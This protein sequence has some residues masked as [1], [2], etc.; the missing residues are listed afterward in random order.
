MKP[1]KQRKQLLIKK[2]LFL[3]LRMDRLFTTH[4]DVDLRTSSNC[5]E[6]ETE[7][8]IGPKSMGTGYACLVLNREIRA[9][10]NVV[11]ELWQNAN[12]RCCVDGGTNRW[13]QFVKSF[14]ESEPP[15]RPPEFITGDFDSITEESRT[16]FCNDV[17]KF[18][19][20][21]DQNATDFTKALDIVRPLLLAQ[22]YR[23]IIVFH[24]TSGRFD[25]IM[26]NIN[27]L[28]KEQNVMLNL[29]LLSG[30]S[31]TWLLRPGKHSI[32]VPQD[33][34]KKQ[35]WCSLIPISG[36][37]TVHTRGLKWNIE[38]DTLCFGGLVSTSNTYSSCRVIV[39]TSGTLVWSMGVFS[40]SDD[41]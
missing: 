19:R 25:Q 40:F 31:L 27:T 20:T 30:S 22:N 36:E 11:R 7:R 37:M 18:I 2:A 21:P 13:R 1:F 24:D 26:G 38:N 12:I 23:D 8:V 5:Y 16:Y 41:D 39:E 6:W 28:Y 10:Q 4:G 29:Y 34:V 15:L 9:P 14:N 35:R 32:S 3:W 33:L 17:T